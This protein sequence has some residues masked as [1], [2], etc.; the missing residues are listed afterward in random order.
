MRKSKP[1]RIIGL[2]IPAQIL[3]PIFLMLLQKPYKEISTIDFYMFIT[4][5]YFFFLFTISERILSFICS[6]RPNGKSLRNFGATVIMK[7]SEFV[8]GI[9]LLFASYYFT[10]QLY[11]NTNFKGVIDGNYFLLFIDFYFYALTSFVMNNISEIKPTSILAKIMTTT[12]VMVSFFTII[13]Y[14]ANYKSSGVLLER[15][16]KLAIRK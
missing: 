15:F 5:Y 14:I 6:L 3:I 9:S 13:L 1:K 11:D 8:F 2:L 16:E 12:E 7:T 4:I 10:I